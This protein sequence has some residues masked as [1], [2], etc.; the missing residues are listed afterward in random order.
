[1]RGG[2]L[3]GG[4]GAAFALAAGADVTLADADTAVLHADVSVEDDGEAAVVE[5]GELA[6]VACCLLCS[7]TEGEVVQRPR[8]AKGEEAVETMAGRAL[9]GRGE[10]AVE[11]WVSDPLLTAT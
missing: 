3:G 5:T 8:E 6:T 7:G 11:G 2:I 9:L 10:G 1:M 4:G